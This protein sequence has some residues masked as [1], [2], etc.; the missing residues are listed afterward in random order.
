M[1]FRPRIAPLASLLA[2]VFLLSGC[3][4]TK[5]VSHYAK[6]LPWPGTQ[7]SA[8]SYK[9]GNPYKVQNVWYYPE[10]SFS[11]TE[12]GI[13]SWYG[14]DFHG[15]RT[16]N[17]EIYD[18]NELTAAHRTLQMPS[19]V[20]VTNLENGRSVV[21]R[22][23]DRG[24]FKRGRIID[25]SQ[26]AADLLGFR[27]KGTARV[28][29]QVLPQES[30]QIAE[31]ARRGLDTSR[32]TLADLKR[33]DT[34]PQER[35]TPAAYAGEAASRQPV[36][37][38][39]LQTANDALPESL[40]TPTITVEELSSGP[41]PSAQGSVAWERSQRAQQQQQREKDMT[42]GH[43]HGGRFMPEPVVTQEPVTATGIFVQAGSFTVYEN[44]ENVKK[45]FS[46]LAPVSIEPVMVKGRQFYRVKLGPIATVEQADTILDEVVRAGNGTAKVIKR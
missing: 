21:V 15:K 3:A 27:S 5:F 43:L 25:V 32:I 41:K 31:A 6:K 16:A 34:A 38:A 8:G 4:E 42:G 44:A 11:L 17:G 26:R 24:P 9:V 22:I 23:N 28:R 37:V 12:T 7:E 46:G 33:M 35:V 20:R 45:Q 18:K 14:P 40:Q 36:R 10:E 13:A 2:V 29:V 39:E 30:R 19:L 1:V